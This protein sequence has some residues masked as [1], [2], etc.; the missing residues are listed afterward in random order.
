MVPAVRGH[1]DE[2]DV[3]RG[4]RAAD[5]VAGIRRLADDEPRG[6]RCVCTADAIAQALELE[7]L[8][9]FIERRI[10]REAQLVRMRRPGPAHVQDDELGPAR[11]GNAHGV[12]EHPLGCGGEVGG[13]EDAVERHKRVAKALRL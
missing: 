2:V 3:L 9:I 12:V 4:R 7:F 11:P 13:D 1:D 6:Q 10:G 8:R 5:L